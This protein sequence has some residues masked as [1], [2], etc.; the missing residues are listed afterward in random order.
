[1]LPLSSNYMHTSASRLLILFC[2]LTSRMLGPQANGE[3]ERFMHVLKKVI[4][5]ST[6]ERK[7]WKQELYTFLR[8]YRATPHSTTGVPPATAMFQRPIRTRL[9]EPQRP[10]ADDSDIREHDKSKKEAM[11]SNAEK[12]HQF[13]ESNIKVG[14]TVLVKHNHHVG[15]LNTPFDIRPLKVVRVRGSRVTAQRGSYFITWN[16]S[17]FKVLTG[18]HDIPNDI[19]NYDDD[20]VPS[21]AN[22]PSSSPMYCF[23]VT[24][25]WYSKTKIK[26][27]LCRLHVCLYSLPSVHKACVSNF[28]THN[29]W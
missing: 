21:H 23:K 18:Q 17:H 4:R 15:K 1:M 12:H 29:I 8:N 3:V 7:S 24:S 5:T 2:L 26:T 28:N 25:R 27:L 14:D 13:R 10:A 20:G 16:V 19:D 11:K 22:I 6:A 9:P